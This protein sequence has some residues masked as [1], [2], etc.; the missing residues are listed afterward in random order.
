M[1]DTENVIVNSPKAWLLAARPKTLTCA[2]VPVMLGAGLAL[3]SYSY[4]EPIPTVLCFLFA[5]IMQIDA[6]FVNDYFDFKSGV[7]DEHRMGPPRA[8]EQGWVTPKA[9]II[10]IAITTLLAC[11]VGLPLVFY[12]GWKMVYVGAACV[13]CCFLY[14]TFFSKYAMG[15]L[16]VLIFF[17]LVP[18]CLTYYLVLPPEL[19][20]FPWYVILE[21]VACGLVVDTLLLVNNYRDIKTDKMVGKHTLATIIG[22]KATLWVYYAV[23]TV[24]VLMQ[25]AFFY[26]DMFWA[27]FASFPYFF[28]HLR[29][30]LKMSKS[31]TVKELNDILAQTARNIFIFGLSMAIAFCFS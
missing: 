20:G 6:N 25:I 13:V 21:G 2:S 11:A 7:D 8:C 29:T 31:T 27:M 3:G 10:A 1:I 5:F 9:M 19:R 23:G 14:T 16:L 28:L 30:S 18:V 24:A 15:D 22:R 12:G 17:G 26:T 4:F